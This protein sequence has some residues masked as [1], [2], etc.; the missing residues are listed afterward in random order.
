MATW[1]CKLGAKYYNHSDSAL[2]CVVGFVGTSLSSPESAHQEALAK[3]RNKLR[4]LLE[5]RPH[6]NIEM[7]I[8][9]EH[10]NPGNSLASN[11]TL[12]PQE[13]EQIFAD[14]KVRDL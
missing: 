9:G 2:T 8:V 10:R 5:A 11:A 6:D 14:W 12:T 4:Q 13:R 3:C 1:E 7:E